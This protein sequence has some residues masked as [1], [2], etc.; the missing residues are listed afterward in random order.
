MEAID[1]LELLRNKTDNSSYFGKSSFGGKIYICQ[2][3]N[4][5]LYLVVLMRLRQLQQC[6]FWYNG[7]QDSKDWKKYGRFCGTASK[8]NGNVP[9]LLANIDMSTV[10]NERLTLVGDLKYFKPNEIRMDVVTSLEEW[11]A[12]ILEPDFAQS[13]TEARKDKDTSARFAHANDPSE[14][15]LTE[16]DYK[17]TGVNESDDQP[18]ISTSPDIHK[19][20]PKNNFCLMSPLI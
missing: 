17:T 3:N 9:I 15:I 10:R 6:F 4:P 8:F 5:T 16:D 20:E 7:I 12:R 18:T 13:L 11:A 19:H 1:V 2:F 14:F